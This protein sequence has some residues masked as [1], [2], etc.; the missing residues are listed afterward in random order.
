M[1][2]N[3]I[4]FVLVVAVSNLYFLLGTAVFYVLKRI[5]NN[6][7]KSILFIKS[8]L[9]FLIITCGIQLILIKTGKIVFNISTFYITNLGIEAALVLFLKIFIMILISKESDFT[10]IFIRPLKKYG[11][12]FKMVL[13]LLPEVINMPKNIM[14]PGY[15]FK[16]IL[17]K[18]FKEFN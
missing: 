2:L 15:S 3:S 14:K 18:S 17:K 10:K 13:K 1:L 6:G 16:Q 8:Y 4:L 5:Y 9:I 7:I 11:I 12:I